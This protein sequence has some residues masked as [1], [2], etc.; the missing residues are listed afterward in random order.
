MTPAMVVELEAG[1][2][3]ITGGRGDDPGP[4]CWPAAEGG[5]ATLASAVE[6]GGVEQFRRSV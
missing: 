4:A 6:G 3:E 1:M 2:S 5:V